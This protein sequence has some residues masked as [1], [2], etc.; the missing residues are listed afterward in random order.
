MIKQMLDRLANYQ[1]EV[2]ALSLIKQDEIDKILTPEI[3]QAI[4]DIE[5]EFALKTEAARMNIDELT[6][7]IKA[8]VIAEG[9]SV[10]G[11]FLHAVYSKPRV[12]WDG[13]LLE[14]YAVAHPEINTARKI[15]LPSVS[16]RGIK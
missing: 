13:K 9:E 4:E 1:A 16:I 8:A 7:E 6:G 5:A 10:K 3:K 12:T 14:G 15:G 2:D 11:E